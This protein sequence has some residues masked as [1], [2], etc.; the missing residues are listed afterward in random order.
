MRTCILCLALISTTFLSCSKWGE[1]LAEGV[2][3]K[4]PA[5]AENLVHGLREGLADDTLRHELKTLIAG[6]LTA[7]DDSLNE[8]VLPGINVDTL[9]DNVFNSLITNL[10]DER[11]V[12]ALDS[13]LLH[14]G[15]SVTMAVDSILIALTSDANQARIN[16]FLG[17]IID[18][19]VATRLRRSLTGILDSVLTRR[20][21]ADL[22][23]NL[24]NDSTTLAIQTLVDSVM[25]TVARRLESDINPQVERPLNF[26]KK[27]AEMLLILLAVLAAAI[28]AFIWRQRRRYLRLAKMLTH[29]IHE[30]PDQR[31]YDELTS[32]ISQVAKSND[33]EKYLRELLKEDGILGK[34]AW[35]NTMEK[36]KSQPE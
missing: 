33:I 26:I 22:R 5:I 11:L 23:N 4:A 32:R 25:V 24:L 19:V 17:N 30:I 34:E 31:A 15:V 12:R 13:I 10:E 29:Q 14:T 3:N 36:R 16:S 2:G 9:V 28:V 1:N 20:G 27:Q 18:E 6:V 7:V 21:A 8:S 35:V